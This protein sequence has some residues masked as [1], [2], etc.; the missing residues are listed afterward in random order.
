MNEESLLIL[1][2]KYLEAKK[3]YDTLRDEYKKRLL[4]IKDTEL[5]WLNDDYCCWYEFSPQG[6]PARF[7]IDYPDE[8][9]AI[10]AYTNGT[11]Q[12]EP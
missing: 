2:T 8:I 4:M 12:W 1:A 10:E 3:Q 7:S 9:S 5:V 11:I 6:S